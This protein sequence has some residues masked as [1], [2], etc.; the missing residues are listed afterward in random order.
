MK[1]FFL[2]FFT[3]LAIG[4]K[5][6]LV[7]S[8]DTSFHPTIDLS[9]SSITACKIQP[10][11]SALSNDTATR[12]SISIVNDNLSDLANLNV[13]FLKNDLYAIKSFTFTLQGYNYIDWNDNVYLF[14]VAATYIKN[15]YG[16]VLIFK[17]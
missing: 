8:I 6:Q 13:S 5:A 7:T 15:T 4:A 3:F 17:N 1:K 2:V 11:K 10:I 14:K 9:L 16:I 12:L